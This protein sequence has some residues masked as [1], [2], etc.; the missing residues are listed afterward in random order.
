MQLDS[1]DRQLLNLIQVEFPLTTEPYTD[2]GMKLGVNS[3]KILHRIEKFKKEEIIRLIGP[4]FNTQNL[5]YRTT[6]VAMKIDKDGLDN[7]ARI[8]SAHPR[9]SH[10]YE[11][12]N[13]FNFWFTLAMPSKEDIEKE[14]H[15]LSSNVKART[16]LNL[17]AVKMF[18]IG[19]Y[20][21]LGEGSLPA[22]NTVTSSAVTI[23]KDVDL[24]S[25]DRAVINELQQDLPVTERPFDF[26]STHLSMNID[27]FLSHCQALIQRGI[28]RRYSA[29]I[30]HNNLGFVANAM[31]C[32]QIPSDMIEA[33]GNKVASFQEISHCYERQTSLLWQYNLYAMMHA[34]TREACKAIASRIC[35]EVGL[36]K[37]GPALLFSTKEIKKT[38]VRYPV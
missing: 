9:I 17:P 33:I 13:D 24:S 1:I 36:H 8:I 23:N 20:F 6:L 4:V 30:S 32:W 38:R 3:N 37:N 15:E 34:D 7:A 28:M 35:S 11:R 27:E 22:Q 5:N 18:K 26:M 10:C 16:T 12:D 14:L 31:A 21:N 25:T 2:M 29:S 19:A